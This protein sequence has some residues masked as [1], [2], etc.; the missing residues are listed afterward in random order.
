MSAA[1]GT[2]VVNNADASRYEIVSGG[3]LAGF[4]TYH[5]RA[6]RIVFLH[7]EIDPRYRGR[8]LA[9]ELARHAV[10]DA[11]ARGLT[12]VPVCPVVAAWLREHPDVADH[13]DWEAAAALSSGGRSAP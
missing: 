12:I 13:V 10:Q 4:T 2:H 7:T 11:V 9:T 6:T 1:A 5:R 8:G 3:E